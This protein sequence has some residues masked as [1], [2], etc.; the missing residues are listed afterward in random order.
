MVVALV[1]IKTDSRRER[2]VLEDLKKIP[3]VVEAHLLLGVY[4]LSAKIKVERQED[5]SKIVADKIRRI[6]GISETR[7]LPAMAYG[8]V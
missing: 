7:T 5:L 4:D 2:V 8:S 3:E 6:P 1:L